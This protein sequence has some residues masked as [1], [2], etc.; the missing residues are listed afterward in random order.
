MRSMYVS[1]T[2][3]QGLGVVQM[4]VLYHIDF[5]HRLLFF[6]LINL[7]CCIVLKYPS[8][9]KILYSLTL[10][11]KK[12]LYIWRLKSFVYVI[13]VN[14]VVCSSALLCF[15][16]MHSLQLLASNMC[17]SLID[18]QMTMC[19]PEYINYILYIS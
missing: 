15:Y 16:R 6:M 12:Q 14:C 9:I 17:N 18:C 1:Y 10:C 8:Q 5:F 7:V 13:G 3:L 19:K 2:S 11:Q 4:V